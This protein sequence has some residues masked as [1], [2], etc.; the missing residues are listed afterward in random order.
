MILFHLTKFAL[1]AHD[2]NADELLGDDY[3][4][5][6]MVCAIEYI[7]KIQNLYVLKIDP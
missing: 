5:K 6:L 7:V 3:P 4:I 1:K 2:E